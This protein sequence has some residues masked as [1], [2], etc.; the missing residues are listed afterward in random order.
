MR[1]ILILLFVGSVGLLRPA[2]A[3]ATLLRGLS[4]EELCDGSSVIVRG[5]VVSRAAAW[6]GGRIYTRVTLRVTASLRGGHRAGQTVSFWRLGG[7]VGRYAQLVRGAPTFRPGEHV[8]VFLQRRGGHRFV[9][10]M[11]QGRF[12]ILP[13]RA[14]AT[15]PTVTQGL[16]GARLTGGR[17]ALRRP[18]PLSRFE[19]RIRAV[20]R[21]RPRRTP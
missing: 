8:L 17:R 10:G 19:G 16:A 11:A 1:R 3:R 2:P 7:R 21:R 6:R 5:K 18:T 12:T 14:T 13:A 4:L 20:L 9:T 15:Q